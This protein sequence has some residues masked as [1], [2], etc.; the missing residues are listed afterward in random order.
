MRD[1]PAMQQPPS[2]PPLPSGRARRASRK[3]WVAIIVLLALLALLFGLDRA[4]AAYAANRIA[5]QIQGHGFPVKPSVSVEGFPFLTQLIT[6]QLDS[7]EI[8][9]PKFPVGAATASIK[10]H[11][12]GIAL[13]S[14]Y[15]SGTIAQVTGTGLIA[16]SSLP[17]LAG[18]SNV[19]G[20][21]IS[22]AGPRTVQLSL[23][24]G[25]V[26]ASAIARVEKTGQN[27][28]SIQIISS[29]G[30]P[31]SLLDPIRH[32]TVPIPNLPLGLAVESVTV[33]GQGVLVHVAG[34]NVPFGS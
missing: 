17:S 29:S 24:L 26:S 2:Y 28:F 34:S 11:A 15:N 31:P 32:V 5:T 22:R 19:P 4:A 14:G 6:R 13:N 20:L 3:V 18:L 27:E 23:N 12:T 10:V 8:T 1:E 30:I 25:I 7:V 16:F 9:A 33:T 21:K